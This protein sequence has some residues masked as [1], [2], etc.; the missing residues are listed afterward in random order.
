MNLEKLKWIFVGIIS[1]C[2][3][4]SC[5]TIKTP[6]KEQPIT[7]MKDAVNNGLV[8]DQKDQNILPEVVSNALMPS[9]S[10]KSATTK[11]KRK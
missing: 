6:I 11:N 10:V 7:Q 1:M 8:D 4:T 2:L 9:L 3:M 5:S